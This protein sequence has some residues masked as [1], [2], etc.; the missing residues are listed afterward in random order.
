VKTEE[1]GRV[2]KNKARLVAHGFRQKEGIDF[3]ES[4]TP[5]ARIEAIRIFVA[6]AAY[7]NMTIYQMDVKTAFLN[8]ELKEVVYVSQP[9]GFVDQENL[10]HVYK[11]KKALY[12]LKQA[13]RACPR[14]I[15]INQSKYASEI[16]KKYGLHSTDSVDTPMI[17]NKKLDEDLQGKQVD[18]TLYRGMI[19]SLMYLTASRPDLNYAVCLCARRSTSG[20]A[21]F[22]GDKLV[23]W[24]S[25]KQ[26]STA[27]SSTEA[28]YIALS[29]CCSQIL[30]MRSQLTGYGFQF[31]KI[32]LYCDNKSAIALCCNNVQH[33]RAKHIDIR[34]HFIKEQVENGIVELYFIRTEYQLADIF[35]K[36]LPRERFNFLIDKL[37]TL[38]AIALTPCYPAFLIT[39]D[40]PE[41]YIHQF[42]NSVYK[43][44]DFY[45]FKIDKNKRFK[46]TLEVFRDVFQICPRVQDQ[47]FDAP[48]TE[49]DTVSFLRDLSHTR[50][51]TSLNDKRS[52]S[53]LF[54]LPEC[55]TSPEMKESKAYKT[56]LGYATGAVP[57]KIARNFK[58]AS[59]TKKDSDLVPVDEER[60]TKGKRI[61]TSVKKSS[62]K[63]AT[64]IELLSEVALT[65]KAQLK[66]VRKKSLRDFHKTHPSGSGTVAEKPP[67]VEK[68]TPT[69][70]SEGTGDKPGVPDVTEDDSTESESESW[71]NDE[72]DNNNEQEA[73]DEGSGQENESEEQESD[74]EQDE[75]SDDDNQEEEEVDQENES[76]DDEIESD[77]DKGMDDTTDQFDDDVDARLEEPTQ[78][79]KEVVQG[80]G[81][82]VEMNEAQQGNENLETTQEQV[83]DDAHV[84]ITI[85]TKKT[86][87][88]VTSSSRSSDLASKFLNFSD[89]PQADAE[90]VSPLDVH[91]HHE[92]PRTQAPTLLTI[93][94]SVITESS[95]VLTNIP[96]S[97]QTFTPLPILTTPTP[98][99][100]I[101]TTNPLL[102]L[103]AFASVFRFN[104][105]ITTLEKEVAKLKKDPLHTQV[106][107]L[108]DEHLDTRLGETREEFMNFL[109]ESLTARIKEKLI[110]ESRDEVNLAK[111][112]SQPHSTYEAASTLTEFDLKKILIDKMEKSE[113][114]LAAP[115]H[116]DCY[117][118]LKKSYDLDK[119]FFFS[120]DVYSLKRGRK[121]KDKDEDPSAGSD[122]GLKKRKTSKDAEPTTGQKKKD[123]TSG[124]SKS[125]KSQP[126]SSGKSV[127]S[128]E[129]VFEV[130]DSD[131]LQ[132]QEGNLGDNENEPRNETAS[133]RDWFKKPTPPQEP[134]D[135]DWNIGKTTQEGPTQNWLMTLAAST[136]TDKSLK[137]FDNCEHPIDFSG[138]IL[139]WALKMTNLTQ[140]ALSE[141]LD[142]ENPKGGD[143]PFDLSKPLPLIK[144]GKRQRVPFK[145]FINNDLK[146]L[147]GGISTMTYTSTLRQWLRSVMILQALK[148][149]SITYEFLFKFA[150]VDYRFWGISH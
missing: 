85:V 67:S 70:T 138:Y 95:P 73:S 113:S 87:V 12:G 30:W 141:K 110:K 46:L 54:V 29:G 60:V 31:N 144:G 13:P 36:P 50:D 40:V 96:Q 4:F 22:L 14:G 112:S 130:V 105:R 143:Y 117:D 76:E 64:G 131:M 7:K 88:P 63:P 66:E 62:T 43:H 72:D 137:D 132:D 109:S 122:R 16:V 27:I 125:T 71:G 48:P 147:Q 107:T 89:I 140:E 49:E 101:E 146:Y 41:V 111:V 59:P 126:K 98:P 75:E 139:D 17:E 25:K 21:Q 61:K 68:I 9:E 115:E 121:D 38:D 52:I 18:A 77:E 53:D 102:T 93:P 19:G 124:S 51:I 39:A 69:V 23:S 103:P 129:P 2:L 82:D 135:P 58:K 134:T 26:K 55:L 37:V 56:Y 78:T 74:S 11:L 28:E 148:T 145:F 94:V 45:R 104:D 108:V 142:W 79:G 120:Y 127:Q 128:E 123:S 119:D 91:V 6:N 5:V 20:S 92:V 80:E 15:F 116:R 84:T 44:D 114:Y 1:F 3:E 86:E 32:P 35:T 136:S 99:P 118:S 106:T 24:S 149:S 97:S 81:A 10:S 90:I 34:Y 100:T 65:E 57:P 133:R 33:S 8:G 42:W 150:Y 83:V 47:D